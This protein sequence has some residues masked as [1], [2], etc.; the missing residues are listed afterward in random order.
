MTSSRNQG[1][2]KCGDQRCR[3]ELQWE[4]TAGGEA[5]DGE[6]A[7]IYIPT[8]TRSCRHAAALAAR[9]GTGLVTLDGAHFIARECSDQVRL[10]VTG[11][12][13]KGAV[14]R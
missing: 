11:A 14:T 13:R 9:L 7:H 12:G 1:V 6:A 10:L 3:S 8:C 2:G 5:G 4:Y